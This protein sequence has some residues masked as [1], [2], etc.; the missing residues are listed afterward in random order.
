MYM[1][2][3]GSAPFV[4]STLPVLYNQIRDNPIEFR[5]TSGGLA[6]NP[7][8]IDLLQHVLNKNPEERYTIEQIKVNEIMMFNIVSISH[9]TT[10]GASLD[11]G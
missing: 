2:V 11:A 3:Y 5:A 8:L 10:T 4:T 9:L 7:Q 1:F 6:V